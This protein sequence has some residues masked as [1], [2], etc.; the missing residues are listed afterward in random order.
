MSTSASVSSA[1]LDI[2]SHSSFSLTTDLAIISLTSLSFFFF[3]WLWFYHM[4]FED[5][6]VKL[7]IQALFSI[8]FMLSLSMFELIIFEIVDVLSPDTRWLNW[9]F[10]IYVMLI[11]LIFVLPFYMFY[12]VVSYYVSPQP[13]RF[14]LATVLFAAWMYIFYLVGSPFPIVSDKAQTSGLLTIEHGVSRIGVIGSF[15]IVCRSMHGRN[16]E[17][18]VWCGEGGTA[19]GTARLVVM[20]VLALIGFSVYG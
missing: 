20:C 17:L 4:L 6:E 8:T 9:Q 16:G 18:W 12:L 3:A 19:Y 5:Y 2:A 15:A 1:V 13:L 11:L 10:D 7:H 14:G